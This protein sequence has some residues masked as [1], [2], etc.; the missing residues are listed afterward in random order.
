M[1]IEQPSRFRSRRGILFAAD[2]LDL[3][4]LGD[5]ITAIH[6]NIAAIKIGNVLAYKHGPRIVENLKRDFNLPIVLDLKITDVGHIATEVAQV[7]AKSGADALTVTGVSGENVICGVRQALPATCE[8]W[9]FTQFTDP[10]GLVDDDI[11]NNSVLVGLKSGASGFQVPGTLPNR[12]KEV[13]SMIGENA[14]IMCCGMGTQGGTFGEALK[15]GA[16]LEIVGRAIYAASNPSKAAQQI[17]NKI[18]S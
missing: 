10:V 2:I 6:K 8:V 17:R 5:C 1:Q 16:D 12:I 4:R 3:K 7:F 9:V 18:F 14:T 13:R 15:A 11:A